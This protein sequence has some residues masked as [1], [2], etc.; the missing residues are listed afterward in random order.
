MGDIKKKKLTI[1]SIFMG[2]ETFIF[3]SKSIKRILA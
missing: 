3:D 2:G 1:R